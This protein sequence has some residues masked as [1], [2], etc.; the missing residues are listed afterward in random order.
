[1]KP[2][3]PGEVHDMDTKLGTYRR[4]ILSKLGYFLDKVEQYLR[5]NPKFLANYVKQHVDADTLG[6]WVSERN[7]G[8]LTRRQSLS[9]WKFGNESEKF[10]LFKT[11]ASQVRRSHSESGV[12]W[13]LSVCISSAVSA[14][15]RRLPPSLF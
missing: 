13:E 2:L 15:G 3:D 11:L 8:A 5:E 7:H 10:N 14:N 12:L 6:Q 9:R 4:R 1:M